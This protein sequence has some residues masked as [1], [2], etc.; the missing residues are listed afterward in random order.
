MTAA[1]ALLLARYETLMAS[2]RLKAAS[3]TLDVADI[4]AVNTLL[5]TDTRPL[6]DPA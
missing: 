5:S 3:G 6:P 4:Q 2:L 1:R